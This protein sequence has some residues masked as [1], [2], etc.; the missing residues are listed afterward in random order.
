[1]YVQRKAIKHELIIVHYAP[2]KSQCHAATL[3]NSHHDIQT[4]QQVFIAR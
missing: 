1:M 4:Q 2:K 3:I